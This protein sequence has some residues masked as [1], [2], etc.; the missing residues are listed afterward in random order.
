MPFTLSKSTTPSPLPSSRPRNSNTRR[1][2]RLPT[3]EHTSPTFERSTRPSC[4]T[5][6]RATTLGESEATSSR[7]D[8]ACDAGATGT[9]TGGS[10]RRGVGIACWVWR[11]RRST[12]SRTSCSMYRLRRTRESNMFHRLDMFLE[13]CAECKAVVVLFVSTRRRDILRPAPT[14]VLLS[15]APWAATRSLAGTTSSNTLS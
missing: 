5:A 7:T 12:R 2:R 11:D 8:S 15:P 9:T 6:L 3:R 1:S 10:D 13:R 14:R 4:R